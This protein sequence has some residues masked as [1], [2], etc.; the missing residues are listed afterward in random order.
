MMRATVDKLEEG[1]RNPML[2]RA[3]GQRKK[4]EVQRVH[5]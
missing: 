5:Q 4:L 2:Q 1:N 3:K